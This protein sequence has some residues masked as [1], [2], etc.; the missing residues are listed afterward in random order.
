MN[1]ELMKALAIHLR[2]IADIVEQLGNVPATAAQSAATAQPAA[3]IAQP[4][5]Q[6]TVTEQPATTAQPTA[7]PTFE[8]LNDKLRSYM[9]AAVNKDMFKTR[10]LAAANSLSPTKTGGLKA[11]PDSEYN[12]FLAQC[13]AIFKEVG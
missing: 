1:N 8:Q 10:A 4:A 12:N 13:E 2:G 5:A 9:V 11:I 7:Q 3:T 6:P